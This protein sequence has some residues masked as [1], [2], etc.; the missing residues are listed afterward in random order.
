MSES[1]P[2]ACRFAIRDKT[3]FCALLGGL[4]NIDSALTLISFA[5]RDD[6]DGFF[7]VI[8]ILHAIRVDNQQERVCRHSYGV[9]PLFARHDAVLAEHCMRIVE[10]TGRAL[11]TE[12][13]VFLFVDPVLF[14]VPFKPHRY[15]KCITVNVEKSNAHVVEPPD[16]WPSNSTGISWLAQMTVLPVEIAKSTFNII[17][18]LRTERLLETLVSG[19][20]SL[21]FNKLRDGGWIFVPILYRCPRSV[22]LKSRMALLQRVEHGFEIWN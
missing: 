1:S 4:L 8:V 10:H 18:K 2:A 12:A 6:T 15:T 11:E 3:A 14:G 20:P 16:R 22:R 21:K 7:F 19:E 9:P 13:V 5:G 17:N